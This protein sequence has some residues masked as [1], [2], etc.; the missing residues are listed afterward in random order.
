MIRRRKIVLSRIFYVR[1]LKNFFEETLLDSTLDLMEIL[2]VSFVF[3]DGI[4]KILLIYLVANRIVLNNCF[5]VDLESRN[6]STIAKDVEL[7]IFFTI[8]W[9]LANTLRFQ[10]WWLSHVTG[11]YLHFPFGQNIYFFLPKKLMNIFLRWIDTLNKFLSNSFLKI[12]RPMTKKEDTSLNNMKMIIPN[13]I[14]SNLIIKSPHKMFLIFNIKL[15]PCY[16][17]IYYID[18]HFICYL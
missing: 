14:L 9:D 4:D 13:D 6:Q 5:E 3:F 16:L 15:I 7:D 17:I 1:S 10:S 8:N 11:L 2:K 18:F 12:F